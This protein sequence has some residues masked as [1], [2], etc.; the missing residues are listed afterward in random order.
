MARAISRQVSYWAILLVCFLLEAPLAVSGDHPDA[1]NTPHFSLGPKALY[2]AASA[3]RVPGSTD[4]SV[5]EDALTLQKQGKMRESFQTY[6][7]LIDQHPK[8]AVHH[9]R[10]AQALLEGGMAEAARDEARLAVKLQP[11]SALAEKTLADILEYD[12]V[13]RKFRSESDLAGAAEAF[14]A[15]EKLDPDDKYVVAN[16][17]ILLEYNADGLRYGPGAHLP[18]A[19]AEYHKLTEEELSRVGGQ[20]NLALDLFYEG[21]F[22]EA[23]NYAI[24]LN[25]EPKAL[26]IACAA[27]LDGSEAANKEAGKLMSDESNRKQTLEAAGQMLLRLRKYSLGADLLEAGAAGE[28]AFR[29]MAQAAGYRK[30][31]WHEDITLPN[32]P[33]G[34][35]K[36]F[37]LFTMDPDATREELY[38]LFSRNGLTV[39]KDSDPEEI[40][41]LVKNG[42]RLRRKWARTDWLW[43][44]DLDFRLQGTEIKGA[45]SDVLGYREKLQVPS[46]VGEL[47]VFVVKEKGEYKILEA[48]GN[49]AVIGLEILDR[50]A[51]HDLD[52]ARTLLDWLREEQHLS[53][54]DDPFDGLAFPRFWT[55]G[56]NPDPR[57]MKLAAA[58]I[59]VQAKSTARQGVKILEEASE[60]SASDEERTKINAALLNG[61][62]MLDDYEK[63]LAVG[64]EMTKDYPES[65]SV[66][67][68]TAKA[69]GALGRFKEAQDLGEQRLKRIPDDEATEL[70]L[71]RNAIAQENYSAAYDWGKKVLERGKGNTNQLNSVAWQTL[72]FTRPEGPDLETVLKAAESHT[73]DSYL[74]HTLGCLYAEV[75][76]T[77]EAYDVLIRAMDLRD[78]DE[79]N[80]DFWYAFGRIAEQYGE[81]QIALADYAKVTKPKRDID[82]PDSCYRL[83]QNRLKV[84]QSD[85][86]PPSRRAA[87]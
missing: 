62:D 76:K 53:G 57:A 56:K 4:I 64:L 59:L 74:L 15:A 25:P 86:T 48:N 82:I 19:V 38:G 85:P 45:G 80:G 13:G 43:D 2:E 63:L 66:F 42:L 18:E 47:T 49:P 17:A 7:Q 87:K 29:R 44:T 58:A 72:F 28:Y 21:K 71:M 79:P 16:L 54:G 73:S 34:L 50:L 27:A 52:G 83:A 77:K 8:E 22:A 70:A 20:N 26:L 14:R 69:L 67:S 65:G 9:L 81:R 68:S 55:K 39:L 23:R 10:L 11:D 35:A 1:W 6:H 36:K 61:Y 33:Q 24:T 3:P 5:L 31:R 41:R 30:T 12:L 60:S 40:E 78:F 84:L 32:D 46:G 37:L 75:G 51:A